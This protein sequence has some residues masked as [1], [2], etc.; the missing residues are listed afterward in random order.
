MS[1]PAAWRSSA[2]TTVHTGATG[3]TPGVE[4]LLRWC[5][6]S[7]W[8]PVLTVLFPP[9]C[10]GC[11]D[12]ETHLCIRCREMLVP[13][14]ASSC[15]RCGEP[16]KSPLMAGRCSVCM[17][18]MLPYAG[19]RSAY[20]HRGPAKRLVSEFKFGGQPVLGRLMAELAGPAFAEYAAAVAPAERLVVTWVPSHR[21]VER[22]RG[23][24]QA[25][26]LAR[27]LAAGADLPVCVPLVGKQV[28][29]RHQKGL[30]RAGRQGNLH[31]AF[32]VDESVWAALAGCDLEAILLVDDVYTTGA[33]AS[34][35]SR[36]MGLRT[37]LP[38]YVFT[39]SRAV[40]NRVE[41][42]D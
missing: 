15:P 23:Y 18:K 28:A 11:G 3:C 36:V 12:F 9:R 4:R 17:G 33:T 5:R 40:A 30:G 35:L 8:E 13:V 32:A 24:N 10:V 25:E 22:E 16:G 6:S 20:V 21:A 39:F 1:S 7:V 37:G 14:G 42:H 34:E 41:G 38:V 2:V 26:L 31:G 27:H 29:T 19:A